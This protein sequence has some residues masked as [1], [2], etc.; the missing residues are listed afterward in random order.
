MRVEDEVANDVY[1]VIAGDVGGF[2]GLLLGGSFLTVFELVDFI[3]FHYLNKFF[4]KPE[5]TTEEKEKL[6]AGHSVEAGLAQT[7]VAK[8]V[9]FAHIDGN[10]V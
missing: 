2:M 6:E 7:V 8:K 9:Q 3:F 1:F 10:C 4:G 5:L